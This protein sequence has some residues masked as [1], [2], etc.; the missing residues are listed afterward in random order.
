MTHTF[1]SK[2]LTIAMEKRTKPAIQNLK[3]KGIKCSGD[4]QPSQGRDLREPPISRS[5]QMD[6]TLNNVVMEDVVLFH[7]MLSNILHCA[8]TPFNC[9]EWN[10]ISEVTRLYRSNNRVLVCDHRSQSVCHAY[11]N[12]RWV[13]YDN[14]P[15]YRTF[16]V[17]ETRMLFW[18]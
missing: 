11:L 6:H 16:E 18:L 2:S 9:A 8:K 1:A 12:Q 4:R 13:K 3:G 14:Y 15:G 17:T 7:L 5:E 10:L